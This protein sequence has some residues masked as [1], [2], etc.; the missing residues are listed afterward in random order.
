MCL[1]LISLI[2]TTVA[3]A[4]ISGSTHPCY[5]SSPA[6]AGLPHTKEHL[7]DHVFIIILLTAAL[8]SPRP[9]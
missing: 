8:L 4:F 2:Y 9:G 3:L 6:Y 1:F 5:S 7:C